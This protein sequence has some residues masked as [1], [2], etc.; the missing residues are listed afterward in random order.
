MAFW[1]ALLVIS[2]LL[3]PLAGAGPFAFWKQ[4]CPGA[5]AQIGKEVSE[6]HEL[7][8]SSGS[9]YQ[10]VPMG[11]KYMGENSTGDIY[12]VKYFREQARKEFE[13]AADENGLLRKADGS[14]LSTCYPATAD[15]PA[16]LFVMGEDGKIYVYAGEQLTRDMELIHHSSLL[17]GAP[18][19]SAG[20]IFVVNG[21]LVALN[22][23][24]GHYLP[25]PEIF[26]QVI[27]EL[28]K[29]GV[30]VSG[31]QVNGPK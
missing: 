31:A 25:P 19:A 12:S 3:P 14:L 18:V 27:E 1:N 7:R 10:T 23:R 26:Q 17:A 24:S 15:C 21:R 30:D 4:K 9:H 6:S 16:A 13:L 20:H 22:S 5:Y 2:L 28:Q 8:F 29:R 11:R